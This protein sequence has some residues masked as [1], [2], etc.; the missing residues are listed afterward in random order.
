MGCVARREEIKYRG[1]IRGEVAH[2]M[3]MLH[4]A[5]TKRSVILMGEHA[6][7]LVRVHSPAGAV[8]GKSTPMERR[9]AGVADV[10]TL[11]GTCAGYYADKE[12][13]FRKHCERTRGRTHRA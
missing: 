4:D 11:V 12:K 10:E 7:T 9:V 1:W 6:M 8:G 13:L 3:G 5:M 2:C